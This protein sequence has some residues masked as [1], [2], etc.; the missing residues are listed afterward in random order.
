LPADIALG[1]TDY[2]EVVGFSDH[3]S[4]AD[5]WYRLLNLGFHIP[6][7][8]GTD[9][10]ANYASLR[11]PVGMNRVFIAIVGETT[12]EKLHSGLKQGRTFVTNGPLLGLEIDG[13]HPGDDVTLIKPATLPYHVS[14]RSIVP[15]DHFELIFNGHVIASHHL[16]GA[17]TQ[18]D[19]SGRVE[20]PASGWLVLRAWNDHSNPKIQDI[21]PYASTSPIYIT[22]DQKL[23]RSPADAAYFVSWLD[24]VI[25]GAT[26]RSDYNSPQEKQNTLQYLNAARTVFQRSTR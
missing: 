18:A 4:S 13:K 1:N 24:R 9:A 17:R 5:I 25:A 10:M 16:N 3:R 22:V 7:G 14:L 2:Y 8:A 23:P 21:Y 19:V 20:I 6:A 26:A 12:P 15:I 11:G